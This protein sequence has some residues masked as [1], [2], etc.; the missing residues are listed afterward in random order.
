MATT[1]DSR[2]TATPSQITRAAK[3]NIAFA[4]LCLPRERRRDMSDFYAWC[5][6]VD[7]IADNPAS[8]REEKLVELNAWVD[9]LNGAR[10]PGTG[11]ETATLRVREKYRIPNE[12][13]LELINGML[14]DL[15]VVR[16]ESWDQLR[17]YCYRVAGVV[18]IAC[19]T[20]FG[21]RNP[22]CREWG[23]NLGY[24]LQVVNIMRDIHEDFVND[25]RIYIPRE[26][27]DA[28]GYTEQDIAARRYNAGF[29]KLMNQQYERALFYFE[30][31]RSSLP[32]EDRVNM[33]CG[34]TMSRIYFSILRKM[35]RDGFRIYDKRYTLSRAEKLLI[36]S[37]A[38]ASRWIVGG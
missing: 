21:Y 5:R 11:V 6:V 22:G 26:D 17:Q 24:S 32:P 13:F 37:R 12:V 10:E 25:N 14:M 18:G 34:R 35:Q 30:E 27:L 4:L 8:S 3:S 7:D 9:L 38:L 2:R 20:I 23:V 31:T 15:D 33:L 16:Y 28:A 36:L 29:Q 1:A 19:T